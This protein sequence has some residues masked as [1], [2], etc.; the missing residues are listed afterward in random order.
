MPELAR[1]ETIVFLQSVDLFSFCKAEEI[2]RIAAIA[3]E[4]R[5]SAGARI[6][7][8]NDPA[9]CLYCVVQG[10][11]RLDGAGG[12]EHTIHPLGAF[13]VEEILSGRLRSGRAV[14]EL[15]SL[16]LA[17]DAEDFFDL[18]SHNIE[19]VK[20]LFRHLFRDRHA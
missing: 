14:T 15:E 5:L 8:V 1:I 13:G 19:I 9:E 12:E 16:L 2:L 18:L 17:I 6:Y 20:A 4:R 11:V 10:Q 3:S 7:D